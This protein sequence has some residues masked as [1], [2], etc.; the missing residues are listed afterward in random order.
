ML[1]ELKNFDKS[2]ASLDEMVELSA[3]ARIIEAEFGATG[4]DLPGWFEPAVS[5]L[6]R[7]IKSRN[8]DALAAKLRD[9]VSRRAS[10]S[11]VDEKRAQLDRDIAKLQ[12]QAA[13]AGI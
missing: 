2:R 8:H 6:R 4:T 12:E 13:A 10:L 11:T 9:M 7:E 5:S 3:Q 1:S